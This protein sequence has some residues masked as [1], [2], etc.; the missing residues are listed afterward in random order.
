MKKKF[1][2][3]A[4]F[5]GFFAFTMVQA[6]SSGGNEN[7]TDEKKVE[8][9]AEHAGHEGHDHEGHDA[10]GHDHEGEEGHD[11]GHE[12]IVHVCNDNCSPEEGC[13]FLHGEKS[14]TCTDACS[15]DA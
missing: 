15:Q 3:V 5:L 2:L 11:H 13:N 10:E 14:H 12:L 6:C 1:Y 7:T 9:A 4:L 8:K